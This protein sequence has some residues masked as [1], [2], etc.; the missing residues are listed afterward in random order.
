[1]NIYYDFVN[2]PIQVEEINKTF[3]NITHNITLT[4]S[5]AIY[6]NY[7]NSLSQTIFD[8]K[9]FTNNDYIII[10]DIHGDITTLIDICRKNFPDFYNGQGTIP[11]NEFILLGDVFDPI[12]NGLDMHSY[13][14]NQ[15]LK[16]LYDYEHFI[17]ISPVLLSIFICFLIQKGFK[18]TI[19][20]G[21]HDLSYGFRHHYSA[22][23]FFL[24]LYSSNINYCSRGIINKDKKK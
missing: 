6:N 12:N 23:I 4:K 7:R 13:I 5:D 1:M 2:K 20:Y 19:V 22:F 14:N 16:D 21:N 10:G 24:G 11:P 18:I 17:N 3:L 15:L 8:S 9:I